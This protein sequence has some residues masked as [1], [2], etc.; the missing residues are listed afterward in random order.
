V[1][2]LARAISLLTIIPVR[3]RWDDDPALGRAMAAFPLVGGLIGT[4][5]LCAAWLLT[6][7]LVSARAG[8][9]AA[10][11]VLAV[12]E[13]LTGFLHL[14]GWA[15]CCDA[16]LPPLERERRL[17]VMK[18]PHLGSFGVAGMAL[19]LLLKVAA[20]AAI[21][22]S[23]ASLRALLPLLVAPVLGWDADRISDEVAAY[24][25]RVAA[26]RESQSEG[27]DLTAARA[28]DRQRR[29]AR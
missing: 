9:L 19:L 3:A 13:G 7:P 10:V 23:G 29:A 11:L 14:D 5:A 28:A 8:L 2:H 4:L 16:L 18:D 1:G 6:R 24:E 26:E 21:L 20:I 15:D 17:A 22:A 25:A 27:D 12:A